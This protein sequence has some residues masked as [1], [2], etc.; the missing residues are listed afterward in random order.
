MPLLDQKAVT[1]IFANI[2]DILLTNTTFLSS[3]EVRQ[4]ECRLYIDNIGDIVETH[5]G[6]MGVYMQYC[7]NT[8]AAIKILQSLRD[9][10]PELASHLQ[11]LRDDPSVRG[12]DLSSYLL[13]PMQRITRYP[14]LIRQILGQTHHQPEHKQ[15]EGSI[16][17]VER[18]LESINESIRE[19][20]GHDRLRQISQGLWIDQGRLDLTE[21]TRYMGQRR[22]LME[23]PLSKIKSSRKLHGFLCSDIL[24]LTE[25]AGRAL[26]R[27]PI[28]LSELQ[29]R[30]V[31]GRH[32]LDF[33]IALAYPRG[34]S[35]INLRASSARDAQNWMRT[36]EQ[37][38]LRCIAAEK[39]AARKARGS[40]G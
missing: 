24:V 12:L 26:Y 2:E 22:L 29:V 39:R 18:V 10:K 34:G 30:E 16:A 8:G 15:L 17:E 35:V 37:A 3:L 19:Q 7:V 14:L 20:E 11:R 13:T 23:G 31:P 33:Q 6:R 9:S 25:D 40:M 38:R 21:P 28:P 1:V 4:K 5:M 27:M 36:I 32:D